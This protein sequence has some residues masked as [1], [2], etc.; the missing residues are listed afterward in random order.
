MLFIAIGRSNMQAN[1]RLVKT[2][3]LPMAASRRVQNFELTSY[4]VWKRIYANFFLII[5]LYTR[6]K[7]NHEQQLTHIHVKGN[8]ISISAPDFKP[9]MRAC[10][11]AREKDRSVAGSSHK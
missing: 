8:S 6:I 11:I 9:S 4:T 10:G 5:P 3:I 1:S 7:A 2:H